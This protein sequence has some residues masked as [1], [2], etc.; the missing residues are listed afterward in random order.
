MSPC[1]GRSRVDI[2][3]TAKPKARQA[4]DDNIAD[5]QQLVQLARSLANQRVY[6]MRAEKRAKLGEALSI[7]KKR[8]GELDCI[9]SQDIFAVFPPGSNISRETFSE[10][11]LR[12]LLRQAIVAA[13]AAVETFIGDRVMERFAGALDQQTP[14]ERLLALPMTVADWLDIEGYQRRKWGLRKVVGEE[15][16]KRMASASPSQI[17]I[18]FSLVGEKD[19]WK[20]VDA[21]RHVKKGASAAALERIYERRNIIA[22]SG[23]RKGHGRSAISVDEVAADLACILEIIDALDVLT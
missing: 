14:P 20:R 22:H 11:A 21:H 17:G 13:C 12:P 3:G 4:F 9:E 16:R 5:A 2:A 18:A 6:R 7:P 10:A 1:Q 19:L 23:D 15:V 8:H